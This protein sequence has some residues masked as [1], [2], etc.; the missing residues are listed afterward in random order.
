[1]E[2][3]LERTRLERQPTN[4]TDEDGYLEGPLRDGQGNAAPLAESEFK[5]D[6]STIDADDEDDYAE[7]E[8]ENESSE[9][10]PLLRKE[11]S[12]HVND[13]LPPNFRNNSHDH[14][15]LSDPS[16]S[17]PVILNFDEIDNVVLEMQAK[18]METDLDASPPK[19]P[20]QQ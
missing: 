12:I 11:F 4:T 1:M 2:R 8:G 3:Y 19:L 14:E 5:H 16:N 7:I 18:L 9:K 20:P 13:A 6:T 15:I 10:S 17:E